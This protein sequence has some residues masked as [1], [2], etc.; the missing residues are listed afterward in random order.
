[1]S[2]LIQVAINF[3]SRRNGVNFA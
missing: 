2:C 3:V 1:M